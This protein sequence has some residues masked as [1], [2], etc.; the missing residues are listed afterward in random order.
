MD[1]CTRTLTAEG[2]KELGHIF[3]DGNIP[4]TEFTPFLANLRG[5]K[6]LVF[7]VDWGRLTD[8]QQSLVLDYMS[9]KFEEPNQERIRLDIEKDG[10]FP[11]LK[12]WVIEAYD[13][14]LLI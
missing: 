4:L 14:R 5:E 8:V 1:R 11:I 10:Y 9:N 7:L 6:N 12:K 13:L 3:K 2:Q